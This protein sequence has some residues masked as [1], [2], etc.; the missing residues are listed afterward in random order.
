[1]FGSGQPTRLPRL[2]RSPAHEQEQDVASVE[3]GLHAA[4]EDDHHLRGTY[5]HHLIT[6][7]QQLG[8][9]VYRRP[10]QPGLWG[11]SMAA[12]QRFTGD[13]LLRPQRRPTTSGVNS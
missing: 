4:A 11:L 8:L 5:E 10:L 7:C 3:P 13:P 9:C 12:V 2:Q 6:G 1:M